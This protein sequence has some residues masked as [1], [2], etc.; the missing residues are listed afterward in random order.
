[1]RMPTPYFSIPSPD[2]HCF[3]LDWRHLLLVRLL[4]RPPAILPKPSVAMVGVAID[5]AT[6]RPIPAPAAH[7]PPLPTTPLVLGPGLKGMWMRMRLRILIRDVLVEMY[8]F[9][10]FPISS[11]VGIIG[12]YVPFFLLLLAS[13]EERSRLAI[14]VPL[15]STY[16]DPP[17]D[18]WRTS[19]QR[20]WKIQHRMLVTTL[21]CTSSTD[22]RTASPYW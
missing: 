7:H 15:E 19:Y 5:D 2:A 18:M 9:P 3:E 13:A 14:S 1:M 10:P 17:R 20:L 12:E 4:L 21:Q 16:D 6:A 8:R 22:Q 11:A